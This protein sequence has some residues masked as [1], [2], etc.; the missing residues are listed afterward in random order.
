MGM[1]SWTAIGGDGS[2]GGNGSSVSPDLWI[3]WAVAVP[4]TIVTLV[5]WAVWWKFEEYRYD[6]DIQRSQERTFSR[7][8]MCEVRLP[9]MGR[10]RRLMRC[11]D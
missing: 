3:Y 8:N 11:L 5:G 6:R 10:I 2:G 1:F 4:L 7:K 9:L